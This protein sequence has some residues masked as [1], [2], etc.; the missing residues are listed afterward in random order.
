[1]ETML[2][3]KG[4]V[5]NITSSGMIFKCACGESITTLQD[6]PKGKTYRDL[7]AALTMK[8]NYSQ[9]EII[10]YLNKWFCCD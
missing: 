1:M 8:L 5:V 3:G 2:Q 10:N 7:R 6:L 9:T 4:W